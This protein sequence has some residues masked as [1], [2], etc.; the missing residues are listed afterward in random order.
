MKLDK[1]GIGL[2]AGILVGI[3]IWFAPLNTLA[4][5]SVQGQQCLALTLMTVVFWACG[6][7]QPAYISAIYLALLVL[8]KVAEPSVVFRSWTTM[9]MW[10][11]IGAYLIAAGVKS[12]GLGERIAYWFAIKFI[13]NWKS[14]IIWI[15]II[16][17]VLSVL[18]PHPFPRCFMLL[19][20]M[21][22]VC[23]AAKM[24][25]SDKIKIG[26][27]VFAAAA[28]TGMFLITG[29][30]TLGPL[31][32]SYCDG[33][34]LS[35]FGWMI[36]MCVP[37]LVA[38]LGTLFLNLLLFKPEH[39]IEINKAEVQA[40][41]DELGSL[42][43]TEK[44]VIIWIAIAVCLWLTGSMTGLSI[45]FVTLLIGA[46][47]ALPYIGEV[48][49]PGDWNTVPMN[50]LVFLTAA[51]GIGTVGGETGM[52]QFIASVLL[53]SSVPSN[54]FVLTLLITVI[55]VVIHMFMG[56]VMAV[57]GICIP[58]FLTFTAGSGISPTAIAMMV[59]SAIN[60]HY[61]LPFHNL[62]ILVGVGKDAGGYSASE[63]M[64]MGIPLTAVV[65]LTT[66]VEAVWFHML[67]LM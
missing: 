49:K 34:D 24:S 42:S 57:L 50:T 9:N 36:T 37:M 40:K 59:F 41:A 61:V 58:A 44:R 5:I 14:L 4:E 35:Y 30:S 29:D 45:G 32:A 25:E 38:T 21:M 43:V 20:V 48:L 11:V 16:S 60:I 54:I 12:S 46:L 56:S 19:A 1:K 28:P 55:T 62:A 13:H 52:N 65:F 23:D 51:M 64:K 2:V 3:L 67:G 33:G 47:M 7:A 39:E 31:V 27:T 15:Y 17:L 53:P 66:L 26:F 22:V 18:I 63:C 6:V 10:M 8:F